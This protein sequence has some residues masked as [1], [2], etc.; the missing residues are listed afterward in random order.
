MCELDTFFSIIFFN[1]TGVDF[2]IR[3]VG[4]TNFQETEYIKKVPQYMGFNR[5]WRGPTLYVVE[6]TAVFVSDNKTTL[7]PFGCRHCIKCSLLMKTTI[8][9]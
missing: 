5:H 8:N 4:G 2:S 7:N 3:V 1:V 6:A 9:C